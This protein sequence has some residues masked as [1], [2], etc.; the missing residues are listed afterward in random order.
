MDS[1]AT[2]APSRAMTDGDD[3]AFLAEVRAFLGVA[4]TPD[5]RRAGAQTLGVHSEIE[6]C[7]TWHRRLYVQGWIAPA[8]PEAFG[9]PG[10][11]A[12]Q[13]FLF[14]R[15]CALN[16]APVLFATGLRSIGP[17]LIEMGTAEQRARY[18]T[19]MLSGEDLWCQG[20]SEPGAGSD[21]AAISTRAV[22]DG[23]DYVLRGTKIWTTGAHLANR[24]FA[25]VRT[26]D[27]AR[28]QEGLTFLLIDLPSPGLT[29]TPIPG[30]A[31]EHEFNQE[32]FDDVR[33]PVANRIG[34]EGEGWAVAKRLMQL[35]RSNNTPA[36]L[37]RRVFRRTQIAVAEAGATLEPAVRRRLAGLEIE[38]EAFEQM[39]LAAL[40][41]GRPRAN[42]DLRPSMLKLTG[43]ELHQKVA[44]LA[45]EVA[46]PY[47]AASLEALG[48]ID[49]ALDAGARAMGKHLAVRAATIYSGASET[50]RN[51]MA[52]ALLA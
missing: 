39:E 5:L 8:W 26:A 1:F 52:R 30:L 23:D 46:G 38:L 28:R 34:A 40:P 35:A 44:E 48:R 25:I 49:P 22:R 47:A 16:D 2:P 32:F 17:L 50:Q 24:M 3:Q 45:M 51:V 36:A 6:A 13:R 20:F 43:S 41:A 15:E 4:L 10:W 42:D 9:G 11:S 19:P 29:I 7:R 37:V 27:G 12:R 21:L 33:V 14:D 18:I 31:G